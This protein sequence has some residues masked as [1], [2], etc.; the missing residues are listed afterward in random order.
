MQLRREFIMHLHYMCPDVLKTGLV[1]WKNAREPYMKGNNAHVP[2]TL[3]NSYVRTSSRRPKRPRTKKRTQT[4]NRE[5][6][7]FEY[8]RTSEFQLSN[9][10]GLATCIIS[11]VVD[12]NN[13]VL[14]VILGINYSLPPLQKVMHV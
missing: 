3:K 9:L 12:D 6:E 11:P 2:M 4:K 8:G 1:T 5:R 10:V 7:S 14:I 13:V